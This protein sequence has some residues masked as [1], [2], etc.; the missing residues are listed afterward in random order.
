MKV[1]KLF[2]LLAG[3]LAANVGHAQQSTVYP[4]RAVRIIVPFLPGGA[5][6][7]TARVL[8]QSFSKAWGQPV[9]ID[10]RTG[11]GGNIGSEIAAKAEPDGHTLLLAPGGIVTANKFLHK[12]LSYDPEKLVPI[13]K[14]GTGPQVVLVGFKTPIT[15]VKTLIE[16]AKS[17]P[18]GLRYGSAG[19]GSQ[20]HLA[21]ENFLKATKIQGA[22]IPYRG[23][24]L[25]FADLSTNQIHLFLPTIASSMPAI[26]QKL[27]R[28][29]AV[30]S[31]E[32]V[33]QLPDVPT[34]AETIPGFE[35]LGWFGL[36]AP[37]GTSS[38]IVEK[39]YQQTLKS[40]Q[41]PDT[42]KRISDIG[43]TIVGNSPKIFSAEIKNESK[44][45][46]EI[47]AERGLAIK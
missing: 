22:H 13:S 18:N 31:K 7:I 11:A 42:K 43:L 29:I 19:I 41:E 46:A 12:K 20:A 5:A 6:D 21:I 24:Q 39:I 1:V 32:R 9:V 17:Q 37:P 33:D 27:V 40:L 28:P 2:L 3:I 35:N 36:M 34:V 4:K 16:F 23:S 30:T 45:W 10:N 44:L 26:T 47:I 25:A 14:I 8:G 38:P 15:S